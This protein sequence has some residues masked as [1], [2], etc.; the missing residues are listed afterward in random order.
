[1]KQSILSI[2]VNICEV[3]RLLSISAFFIFLSFL[4]LK[5][6]TEITAYR[7]EIEKTRLELTSNIS[8]LDTTVNTTVST[9]DNRIGSIEKRLFSEVKQ[10]RLGLFDEVKTTRENLVSKIDLVRSDI[11]PIR[12]STVTLL[13]TYNQLPKQVASRFDT[14]TDCENNALCIQGLSTDTLIAIRNSARE[15]STTMKTVDS[16]VPYVAE[17][18]VVATGIFSNQIAPNF[19]NITANIDRITKPKWYDR[20]FNYGASGALIYFG[21]RK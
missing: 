13:D 6:N 2:I 3:I 10:T 14:V 16:K 11:I 1:M 17:N 4:I 9:L 21:A 20:I 18:I 7:L 19:A 8:K 5:V 12:D 15:V